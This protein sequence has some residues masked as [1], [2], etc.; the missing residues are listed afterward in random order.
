[1]RLLVITKRFSLG[2]DML[3]ERYGRVRE[4]PLALARLGHEVRGV[5][6]S[7]ESQKEEEIWDKGEE[8]VSVCWHSFS[9]GRSLP[10]GFLRYLYKCRQILR[11]F[12]PDAVYAMSDTLYGIAGLFLHRVTGCPFVFEL[13]D[14]FETYP[15]YRI[16]GVPL[17]YRLALKHSA[18]VTTITEE[19]AAMVRERYRPKGE[20]V[21]IGTGIPNELFHSI[22][23]AEARAALGL[24]KDARLFGTA[25]LL[26]SERGIRC[27]I[28]AHKVLEASGTPC[29]LVLAGRFTDLERDVPDRVIYLGELKHEQIPYFINALDVNVISMRDDQ[30]A[31]YCFPMK[32]YEIFACRSS[33]VCA[34]VGAMGKLLADS[35]GLLYEADDVQDLVDKVR[36][37]LESPIIYDGPVETWEEI[38][39]KISRILERL[40]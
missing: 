33:F 28:E 10:L 19:L 24:P 22:P 26:S 18:A 5:C 32:A 40:S 38:A 15:S 39:K 8:E 12:A 36:G 25:G 21:S 29:R 30:F 2:K 9:T 31:R 17:F 4:L 23:K 14:N 34:R 6:L 37:Q 16:P 7:Y 11:E 1:M 35:P 13:H 27:L 20:V 3:S